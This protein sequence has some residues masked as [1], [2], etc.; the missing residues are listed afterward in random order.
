MHGHFPIFKTAGRRA[1]HILPTDAGPH[2]QHCY[3]F[4]RNLESPY[5]TRRRTLAGFQQQVSA[6]PNARRLFGVAL[7]PRR[8]PHIRAL[9]TPL[10][11][12]VFACCAVAAC[13]PAPATD[14]PPYDASEALATFVLES[15]FRIE[16][17]AAEPLV[18]DP[19]AMDIDEHGRIFVAEMP[20]Y[21]LDASGSGRVKLLHDTDGDGRPDDA[22]LFAEDLRLPT[23]IMRWREG[24][25]VT[26]PP[27][28]LYLA[29]TTGDGVADVRRT[30]LT[31][32]ALSNAQHNANK[33]VYGLDNWIYIANNGTISWTEKYADPFGDQGSEIRFP[34]HPEA[35]LLPPNGSDRNVRF[36]PDAYTLESLSSRSQFG[37]TFDAWGRH[38]LVNNSHHHMHEVIPARFFGKD[39][40]TAGTTAKHS[41]PDHGDA[42]RVFPITV[43]PEHQLLTDRGVFTSACGLTYY[44]GGLF[45]VPFDQAT[46]VAEP[47]HNLVHVDQVLPN[48]PTFTASRIHEGREFLASTDSWFRPVN[49][50]H[51]PDGALYLV[52]YYRHI[53]EHPEWMDDSL[54]A[55][56]NLTRG[57]HMGRLYRI[58]PD[59]AGPLDWYGRIDFGT[60]EALVDHL[61]SPNAWWRMT[62]QRLLVDGKDPSAASMLHSLSDT[63]ESPEARLHAL[64]T[65]EGLNALTPAAIRAALRD[66]HP[67]VRENAVR[68]AIRHHDLEADL[69]ALAVD[70][71]A[72]VQ[73]EVLGALGIVAGS[74]AR[75]AQFGILWRNLESEW[76]QSLALMVLGVPP[77][78]LIQM[79]VQRPGL[80]PTSRD[81]FLQRISA[82]VGAQGTREDV[83]QAVETYLEEAP[84]LRGVAQGL[85][86]RGTAMNGFSAVQSMLVTQALGTG[87]DGSADAAI[88]VLEQIGLP[89]GVDTGSRAAATLK[90]TRARPALRVRASRLLGLALPFTQVTWQTYAFGGTR[91]MSSRCRAT[92]GVSM[93]HR[94]LGYGL[95]AWSCRDA[96][97]SSTRSTPALRAEALLTVDIKPRQG[98][99]IL[100]CDRITVHGLSQRRAALTRRPGPRT[101]VWPAPIAP[102]RAT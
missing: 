63:S 85:G 35:P 59:E 19:V 4:M 21:P 61:A 76:F 66:E 69:K 37:H 52:D 5:C 31:G 95:K 75:E 8:A 96:S 100:P 83:M 38:F 49:F 27:E 32:F 9:H 60:T 40:Y 56:G 64:W 88:D 13:G 22:T 26:D 6:R 10:C 87:E 33:P 82:L 28:V 46:F 62:A 47:V 3:D 81:G 29:D 14:G 48:G 91:S 18:M 44:L 51:G 65:L 54:A 7:L 93:W 70:P 90:D 34:G 41:T 58:A 17:V 50:S 45:P 72:R 53:I 77:R 71:D 30:I 97:F 68:L 89:A 84:V 99:G 36:R 94:G 20:G 43:R 39:G 24:I 25:L 1:L 98:I 74:Q 78:E 101:P 11:I 23:G 102:A 80:P 12:V 79:V 16:V 57:M 67:G 55:H 2:Q 73:F 42:A 92:R 86:Q 15:G